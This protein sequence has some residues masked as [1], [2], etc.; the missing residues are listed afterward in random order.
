MKAEHRHELKTNELVE[1][2]TN[3]PQWA[4]ENLTTIIG[5]VGCDCCGRRS[6]HLESLY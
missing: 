5:V 4:N 6:L 2:L 1:W 3:L